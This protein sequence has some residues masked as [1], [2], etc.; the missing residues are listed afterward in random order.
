MFAM[1]VAYRNEINLDYYLT[2]HMTAAEELCRPLGLVGTEVRHYVAGLD[3]N[4]PTYKVIATLT[5][6]SKEAYE[7]VM[8][9][10]AAAELMADVKNFSES[11]PEFFLGEVLLDKRY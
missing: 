9:H 8:Q 6:V 5:F 1:T 2:K 11:M 4:A 3:G 10:P 7:A